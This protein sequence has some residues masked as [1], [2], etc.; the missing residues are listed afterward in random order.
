MS[1]A[2]FKRLIAS[3]LFKNIVSNYAAVVWMG[4]LS[5]GL[6][7][8]YLRVLGP[9]QWGVVAVC[10]AVQGFLG[11]LDAGL[12]Q[13]MPRDI[14]LTQGDKSK[15]N[16]VFQLFNRSYLVLG[17]LGFLGAQLL[18]PVILSHWL[19]VA[20]SL[21]S[22]ASIVLRLVVIQ[23]FFQF[24]NSAHSGYWN[25]IQAQ[26]T[27]N[28]RQCLFGTAKHLTAL[29]LVM[30]W[31]PLAYAYALPFALVSAL[32][33]WCNRRTLMKE[34]SGSAAVNPQWSEYKTLARSAG[35]LA[36]G[37]FA[38]MLV[39]Q[40]DRIV[41]SGAL[42]ASAYGTYVIVANLGLAF[43]QLQYPLMR[44]FFPRVVLAMHHQ[45]GTKDRLLATLVITLCVAPCLVVALA[46]PW[47]LQT[48]LGNPEVA[49]AG[50]GPLR[51]ILIAVAINAVYHLIYQRMLALGANAVV[52]RINVVV[53]MLVSSFLYLDAPLH[54]PIAG[55][56]AW[57]L[58]ASLQLLM[59][60]W[61]LISRNKLSR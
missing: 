28:F 31:A 43:M 22:D 49:L 56:F 32:E 52:V 19:N 44:A 18:V 57:V 21:Q 2:F 36:V 3:Q 23:F 47:I 20:P 16:H 59:G 51:F 6:I 46:A 35:V 1:G 42:H 40:L 5:L 61:W 48:W 58:S 15:T 4:V 10:M 38:G 9:D 60:S 26:G 12:G 53:L 34:L 54:G 14:A 13:I 33:W 25:G 7:P 24:A 17:F 11:L 27:A 50:V 39:S 37:V 45:T 29:T 41:L 55:G 30:T 8:L